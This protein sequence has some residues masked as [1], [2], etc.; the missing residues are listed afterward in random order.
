M[1]Q[2]FSNAL[3]IPHNIGFK[4][5]PSANELL[6]MRVGAGVEADGRKG[7]PQDCNILGYKG[8]IPECHHFDLD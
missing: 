1:G 4:A 6:G 7:V 2:V 5:D 3:R 8:S